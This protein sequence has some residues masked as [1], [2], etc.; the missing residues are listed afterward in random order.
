M[1]LVA[2]TG[3]VNANTLIDNFD[4]K[5]ATLLANAQGGKKDQTISLSKKS[6]TTTEHYVTW[7]QQDDMELRV[8]GVSTTDGTGGR[9][10]TATLS[11]YGGN[12]DFLLE[13]TISVTVTSNGT[14]AHGTRSDYRTVTG[15]RLRLLKGVKYKL[16]M[17]QSAGTSTESNCYVQLRTRRRRA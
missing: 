10:V 9:T 13:N 5:T 3:T 11:V 1:S 6:L 14:T 2:F 12:D 15:T 4:D 8:I 16:G 7:T 17:V